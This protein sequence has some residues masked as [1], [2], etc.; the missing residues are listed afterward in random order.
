[1]PIGC[2][3]CSY[4]ARC[5]LWLSIAYLFARPCLNF[6]KSLSIYKFI[7]DQ[8]K[9]YVATP[10]VSTSSRI[11]IYIDILVVFMLGI[12]FASPLKNLFVIED[13]CSI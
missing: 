1:M 13:L 7:N 12:D 11:K 6:K 5:Y 8:A 9:A 2:C 10:K 3:S 4:R